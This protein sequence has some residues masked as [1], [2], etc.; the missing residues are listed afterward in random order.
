MKRLLLVIF[1]VIP[2]LACEK[3]SHDDSGPRIQW[4][5]G[6]MEQALEKAKASD[7]ALFVYWGASWCPPCNLLKSTVFKDQT[8]VEATKKFIAVYL[9]GDNESSQH[10][11]E[12]LKASGYPTIMV[13]NPKGEEVVR[14]TTTLPAKSLAATLD[15]AYE[16]L[17]PIEEVV[18]RVLA[19]ATK[20]ISP[21]DWKYLS[22]Y[23]W[24]QDEVFK[25]KKSGKLSDVLA[26]LEAKV[27]ATMPEERSRLFMNYLVTKVGELG[28]NQKLEKKVRDQ[29]NKRLQEILEN[30]ALVKY[31]LEFLAYYSV[32]LIKGIYPDANALR[33]AVIGNYK[34]SLEAVRKELPVGEYDR[35]VTY[36]PAVDLNE[37]MTK[38]QGLNEEDK[39]K[40]KEEMLKANLMVK[41][42]HSRIFTSNTSTY[43]LYKAGMGDIARQILQDDLKKGVNDY[44]TMSSLS[45]IEKESG[46]ADKAVEWSEKAYKAAKGSATK[47]QWGAKH[48]S[49][50]LELYPKEK[51]KIID[52]LDSYLTADLNVNDAFMGR[53]KSSLE[54]LSQKVKD[55]KKTE[56]IGVELTGL[57]KKYVDSCKRDSEKKTKYY[58]TDC[59]NYFKK[60]L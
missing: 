46:N 29:G 49:N 5:S 34:A 6:T 51:Q 60:L 11:G 43:I 36:Y 14:L 32:D 28:K 27:P 13:L 33:D 24:T 25:N 58:V 3:S 47:I 22:H 8:F 38:T 48:I 23:S 44:Y 19:K 16:R 15:A 57:K 2:F 18:N 10:W 20:D 31:N 37:L 9:D 30:T 1:L 53:N 4:F 54:K 59:E 52:Q 26:K 56:K 50:L 21:D 35:M 12:K 41:D 39:T 45:W 42:D 40:I 17:D 7:K 55:W